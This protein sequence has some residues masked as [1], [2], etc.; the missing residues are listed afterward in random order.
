MKHQTPIRVVLRQTAQ[1]K[2]EPKARPSEVIPLYEWE[3]VRRPTPKREGQGPFSCNKL[4]SS[5]LTV[6]SQ[7]IMQKT[8]DFFRNDCHGF[9]SVY[10]VSYRRIKNKK[11]S[12]CEKFIFYQLRPCTRFGARLST[13]KIS[14]SFRRTKGFE[15]PKWKRPLETM[16][17]RVCAESSRKCSF[18][19][20]GPKSSKRI[21]DVS[22]STKRNLQR[23]PCLTAVSSRRP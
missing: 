21:S 3:L 13:V 22:K 10:C 15:F 8:R 11:L 5:Y 18:P 23:C 9:S 7:L 16:S 2:K 1:A 6:W 20:H 12:L 19:K 4:W 14:G 17:A